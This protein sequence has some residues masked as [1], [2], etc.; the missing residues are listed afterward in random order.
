[1]VAPLIIVTWILLL[2]LVVALC[3]AARLGDRQGHVP[4]R[5]HADGESAGAIVSRP[6]LA[7]P[8]RS[9]HS[10]SSF[11]RAGGATG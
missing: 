2:W 9:A 7:R 1:M 3:R 4:E 10:G 6:A 11:V 5:E 8:G